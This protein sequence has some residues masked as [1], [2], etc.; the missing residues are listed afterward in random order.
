M[1]ER[2]N[3][4]GRWTPY[5]ALGQGWDRQGDVPAAMREWRRALEIDPQNADIRDSLGAA[6]LDP[7]TAGQS[8]GGMA[9]G[10]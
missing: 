4:A 3:Y 5:Y 2:R 1:W 7:G 6:L 8:A 9:G 10:G